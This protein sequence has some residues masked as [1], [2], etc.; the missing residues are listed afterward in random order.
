MFKHTKIWVFFS[1]VK[2]AIW[3]L[4]VIAIFAL[5]GTFIPQSN[6]Y[7]SW[8][9]I[10]LLAFFSLNLTVC[11]LNRFS[12][13]NRSLGSF[14]AHI[15][16]LIILLGA[17]IG[18]LFGQK[19][20]LKISKGEEVNSFVLRGRK[21][22]LGFSIRLNE[23]IYNESIDAKE[24]LLVY[25]RAK[26]EKG[27]CDMPNGLVIKKH[28]GLLAEI[29]INVGIEQGISNT[30]YKIKVIRYLPD[31]VMDTSTKVVS[32]RSAN[33]DNPAIEVEL[34]D[35]QGGIKSAWLFARFPD[36]HQ[37]ISADFQILYNWAP[38]RPKDF[39]SK[40]TILKAGKEI[41]SQDIQVNVPLNFAGYNFFQ[42]SYDSQ[43]F[44]WTG[45]QVV[46]DPGVP[47]IYAG[48]VLLI[49]G[50]V[51]IFYVGPLRGGK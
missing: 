40:V 2:L 6:I 16:I 38:R 46:K 13:K 27:V 29:P 49:L 36:I 39:I 11:L 28:E 51:L 33:P 15:S 43:N 7:S 10:F 45:L 34:K 5:V 31:F 9:F 17:L 23:F 1:S 25:Q 32:N 42:S 41:L 22:P 21:I 26:L 35:P 4:S 50:L 14:F 20:Y 3:L 48:F 24:K 37:Q 18:I 8:W 12:L 19:D 47:V 30:G 44:S